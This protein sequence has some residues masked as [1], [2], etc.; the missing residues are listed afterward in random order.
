[1]PSRK[2]SKGKARKAKAAA[3]NAPS[4]MDDVAG[5]Y[6]LLASM[7]E[8]QGFDLNEDWLFHQ[9]LSSLS[10]ENLKLIPPVIDC[11]HGFPSCSRQDYLS[12][13][14]FFRASMYS[15]LDLDMQVMAVE[16][17]A[18]F[19]VALTVTAKKYP[20]LWNDDTKRE[21]LQA[22][23]LATGINLLMRQRKVP[24]GILLQV[25]VMSVLTL[26][27]YNKAENRSFGNLCLTAD[28]FMKYQH[29]VQGC[30][31]SIVRFFSTR[32]SCSCLDEKKAETKTLPKVGRCDH[33]HENKDRST[34]MLCTGCKVQQYC[35]K[36]CQR[37]AWPS[38]KDSCMR[39]NFE[40]VYSVAKAEL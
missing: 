10:L 11:D 3:A 35:A 16:G 19:E 9:Y 2:R 38:H 31:R 5:R 33:C 4:A 6:Q 8:Q 24:D 21:L 20:E 28:F 27:N 15:A 7:N 1:M 26:E 30:H 22:Y 17:G 37:A 34:L 13:E 23:F 36:E 14:E 29:I 32:I 40:G 39:E 12:C 25:I 18:S